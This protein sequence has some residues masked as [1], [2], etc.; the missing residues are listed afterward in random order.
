M[1]R[2]MWLVPVFILFLAGSVYADSSLQPVVDG[3]VDALGDGVQYLVYA[4]LIYVGNLL[5]KKYNVELGFLGEERVRAYAKEAALFVEEK[6][7]AQT[8][9]LA[10][11][12]EEKLREAAGLVAK[13]FNLSQEIAE[14]VVQSVLPLLSKAG[15][16]AVSKLKTKIPSTEPQE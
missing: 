5:R 4:F 14:Q 8:D 9:G 11:K 13:R 16:G 7:A 6:A 10:A 3:L 15:V 12:G 1:R 2:Y